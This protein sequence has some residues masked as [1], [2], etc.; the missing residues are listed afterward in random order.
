M[1]LIPGGAG[2]AIDVRT[3]RGGSKSGYAEGVIDLIIL[4][5]K[6]RGKVSGDDMSV[7]FGH[8]Y[9]LKPKETS[10]IDPMR[11]NI[12]VGN[13][14]WM[15]WDE[16][17]Q[18]YINYDPSVEL[19]GEEYEPMFGTILERYKAIVSVP[20]PV[21]K[22]DY[23]R[24]Y[25]LQLPPG[26]D[27]K[28]IPGLIEYTYVDVK[29]DIPAPFVDSKSNSNTDTKGGSGTK[30]KEEKEIGK[31]PEKESAN[32]NEEVEPDEEVR[33]AARTAALAGAAALGTVGIGYLIWRG[34]RMLPSLAPPLWWTI[35]AN[36][37]LP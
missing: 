22:G 36:A 16:Q 9:E 28:P 34:V 4:E 31:L 33:P 12:Q 25:F 3:L 14:E 21:N 35:P 7:L 13:K 5:P 24:W 11:K 19:P 23:T 30:A 32:D 20:I 15:T 37:A 2:A 8:F 6:Y 1:I 18:K 29:N 27:E 10:S 17:L 26:K